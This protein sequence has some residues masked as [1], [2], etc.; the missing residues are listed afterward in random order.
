M[1][2]CSVADPCNATELDPFSVVSILHYR[3]VP[4]VKLL[5]VATLIMFSNS[6]VESKSFV[7]A[8]LESIEVNC[9]HA[10]TTIFLF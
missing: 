10:L 2:L 4:T 5:C 9:L 1:P 7:T 6:T 8:L 3:I